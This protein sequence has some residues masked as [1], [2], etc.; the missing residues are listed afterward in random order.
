MLELDDETFC[1]TEASA[2]QREELLLLQVR[3]TSER[4][5]VEHLLQEAKS[6]SRQEGVWADAQWFLA[7]ENTL[8]RKRRQL[9]W[10]SVRLSELKKALPIRPNFF[11][12][13]FEAAKSELPPEVFAR[14]EEKAKQ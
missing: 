8:R 12:A 3:V 7:S 9:Q 4:D 11:R 5:K 1:A 10:L 14:L 6:R 2:L 13:F